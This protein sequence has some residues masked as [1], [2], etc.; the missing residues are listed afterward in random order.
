MDVLRSA[1]GT[2]SDDDGESD[3]H[4][5]RVPRA[6]VKK[7]RF[8]GP[9]NLTELPPTAT[10]VASRQTLFQSPPAAVPPPPL[11]GR[12]VS[13]RERAMMGASPPASGAASTP[14]PAGLTSPVVGSISDS[15]LPYSILRSLRYE[16]KRLGEFCSCSG[17][18]STSLDHH[19]KVVN[20]LQWSPSHAHLLASAS[21]DQTVCIWNVWNKGNQLARIFNY[22]NASVKDIKWSPMGLSL[23]S[24][25]YDCSSRLVDV[26]KGLESQVFKEDQV[27]TAIRFC[28]TNSELFLSG[29]AKGSLKLWDMR[30]GKTV[31]EYLRHLGSILD[32]EFSKDGKH[33]ISS[34]DVSGSNISENAIIVWDVSREIPLSNQVYAEAYTCPC[35]RYHPSDASFIAQSNGNYIAIFSARHPF[36]LDRY[37]R[38]EGHTVCGYSIKCNFSLDGK[39]IASGSSDG[40]VY[41][42]DYRTSELLRKIQAFDEACIDVAF[43]PHMRNVL[44]ACSWNGKI[45]VFE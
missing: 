34:S 10:R 38:Y 5:R 43:H 35:I 2:A 37:K 30:A 21:L 20:G 25:G 16:A 28:P 1:Y 24:C 39:E 6:P 41:F 23:L 13:K 32:I 40:C 4:R 45:S 36:R 33:F 27:V 22:H 9:S 26:E 3:D 42:Y 14:A 11:P 15:S 7:F 17:Q 19:S 18:L 44:A 31:K 8:D 29:G 12:Y